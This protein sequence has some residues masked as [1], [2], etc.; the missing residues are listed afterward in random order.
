M[1]GF[2]PGPD[3]FFS[4]IMRLYPRAFRETF[5]EEMLEV[6]AEKSREERGAG[7][8]SQIRFVLRE[9]EDLAVGAAVERLNG[10]CGK[11]KPMGNDIHR[12]RLFMILSPVILAMFLLVVNPRYALRIFSDLTGW[13]IVLAVVLGVSIGLLLWSAPEPKDTAS[14][15]REEFKLLILA[16]MTNLLILVGPA[17]VMV[18]GSGAIMNYPTGEY[19]SVL[20][21]FLLGWN[22][23]LAYHAAA[24]AVKRVGAMGSKAG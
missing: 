15:L 6:I 11:K 5:G 20:R 8:L 24:M 1:N 23:W 17:L 16:L 9:F 10:W 4:V 19:A 18:F 13:E 22:G 14:R 12:F 21:W 7:I 3:F 2:F